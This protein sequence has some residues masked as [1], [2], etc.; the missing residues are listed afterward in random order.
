ML[1]HG[2][3]TTASW[4]KRPMLGIGVAGRNPLA[5]AGTSNT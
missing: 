2:S 4:E 3:T 1:V 5:Q